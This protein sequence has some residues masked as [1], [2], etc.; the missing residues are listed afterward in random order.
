[1]VSLPLESLS[2]TKP[3]I[4]L[5]A[6]DGPAVL[7][8]LIDALAGGP[9][10]HVFDP[11]QAAALPLPEA[12][13]DEVALV[14]GSSGSSG[15]PKAVALGAN[16]LLSSAK[17][18][19][20]RLGGGAWLLALP[21]HY[22]AGLNVLLRAVQV[23]HAPLFMNLAVGFDPEG[24]ARS[25]SLLPAGAR[26]TSLVPSQL[27]GLLRAAETDAFVREQLTS[28]EAI[29]VGGQALEPRLIERTGASE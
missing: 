9:A 16:A 20:A 2:V 23:G 11:G 3:L 25:S 18:S 22:I 10:L 21:L 28:F 7:A 14:V 29:L 12:V 5:P 6:S 13:P 17:A 4:R 19:T 27:Q 24:F 26:F 1:M 8:A 15:R